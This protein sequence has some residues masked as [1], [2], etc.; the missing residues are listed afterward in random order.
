M[1]R[2]FL[3]LVTL[4]AVACSDAPEVPVEP[5]TMQDLSADE[6]KMDAVAVGRRLI[7]EREQDDNLDKAIRLLHWHAAQKPESADLQ[8]LAAEACSRALEPLD[9]KKPSDQAR[10]QTLRKMGRSHADAA[11]RLA[12]DNGE[13]HY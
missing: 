8:R 3:S 7:D 11:V 13:A 4:F 9:P 12:P 5:V 6:Q 2:S 10:H 1:K